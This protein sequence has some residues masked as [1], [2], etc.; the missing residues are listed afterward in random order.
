MDKITRLK[1]LCSFD[2]TYLCNFQAGNLKLGLVPQGLSGLPTVYNY[3]LHAD[4]KGLSYDTIMTK[5][6]GF[7][8]PTCEESMMKSLG[9][10]GTAGQVT[11]M[12]N[13]G[14]YADNAYAPALRKR[15]SANAAMK[16]VTTGAVSV[17]FWWKNP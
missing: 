14:C 3:S 11:L 17:L 1:S 8:N 7:N 12:D 13:L 2:V 5:S 4:E 10:A 6:L 9:L 15:Q 16:H